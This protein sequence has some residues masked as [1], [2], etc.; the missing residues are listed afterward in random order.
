M[1]ELAESTAPIQ[2]LTNLVAGAVA[3]AVTTATTENLPSQTEL[4]EALD[5]AV[6][7]GLKTAFD[8]MSERYAIELLGAERHERTSGRRGHRSG[9]RTKRM[10]T[11]LGT[12]EVDVVKSRTGA[13]VPPWLANAK[14]FSNG[15]R[16]LGRRLWTAGL[17]TRKVAQVS[18][19]VLGTKAS[20]AS[21]ASWVQEAADEVLRWLNRPIRDDITYLVLDGLY[22]PIKREQSTKQPILVAMGVTETGVREVLGLLVA[23][24]ENFDSW[25]TMLS[26]LRARGLRMDKLRLVVSDGCEGLIKAIEREL[27]DVPRQR[28]TVHKTRNI[29]G[30]CPK[31]LK[32]V[33]PKEA[34]NIWKAPN[35]SEARSRAQAFIAKYRGRGHD[36]LANIIED[37]LEAT[38]SFFDLDSTIWQTMRST[39]VLERTNRE[40][41]A[42][43]RAIGAHQESADPDND[44]TPATTRTAVL[45]AIRLNDEAKNQ[46]VKGFKQRNRAR[47]TA[48]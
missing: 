18:E 48:R 47:R 16:D 37:D 8:S 2:H 21:V 31:H 19:E 15:V 20:H 13:L 4:S 11:P 42:R 17:S 28:C 23:P 40:F 10:S 7:R 25:C 32:G 24:S 41:R 27:P 14:R 43:F 22:V 26:T 34:S 39:N 12:I 36:K 29:V 33:A 35:R 30:R 46:T 9:S 44:A 38:L 45:V 6:V 1:N 3:K 5:E